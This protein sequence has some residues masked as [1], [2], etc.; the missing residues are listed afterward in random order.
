MRVCQSFR[1][2]GGVRAW[3]ACIG[4][5]ARQKKTPPQVDTTRYGHP[6]GMHSSLDNSFH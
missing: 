6:T 4:V 1:L 5:L 3:G 2:Q